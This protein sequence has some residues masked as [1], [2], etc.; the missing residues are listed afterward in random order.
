[1]RRLEPTAIDPVL[2][3]VATC[4]PV[5]GDFAA[6][7][8]F[9]FNGAEATGVRGAA[10]AGGTG[11]IGGGGSDTLGALPVNEV[12]GGLRRSAFGGTAMGAMAVLEGTVFL[13]A[14]SGRLGIS[15][16]GVFFAGAFFARDFGLGLGLA[17]IKV[18]LGGGLGKTLRLAVLGGAFLL[19]G[20][21]DLTLGLANLSGGLG[22]AAGTAMV[23]APRVAMRRLAFFV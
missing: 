7:F 15:F 21:F 1:M 18:G 19:V 11:G 4:P 5:A 14:L 3:M 10:T 23:A 13:R 20:G 9:F 2:G 17:S 6:D 8:D 12:G 16:A 22:G